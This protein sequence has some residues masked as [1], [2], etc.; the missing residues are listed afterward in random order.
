MAVRLAGALS[1]LATE[2]IVL[3]ALQTGRTV[4]RR[5]AARRMGV[6]LAPPVVGGNGLI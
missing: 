6:Q 3:G 1:W 4:A 5:L 2:S